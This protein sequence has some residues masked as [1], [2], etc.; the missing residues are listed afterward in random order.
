ML[1]KQD[2]YHGEPPA[3]ASDEEAADRFLAWLVDNMDD[4]IVRGLL[5]ECP[6]ELRGVVFRHLVRNGEGHS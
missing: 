1:F 2:V 4:P 3:A 6:P 5:D